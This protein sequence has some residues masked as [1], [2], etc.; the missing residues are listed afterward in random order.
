MI[1]FEGTVWRPALHV[2]ACALSKHKVHYLQSDEVLGDSDHTVPL[3]CAGMHQGG[4]FIVDVG[5]VSGWL[6]YV[7]VEQTNYLAHGHPDAQV[8]LFEALLSTLAGVQ[9][10]VVCFYVCVGVDVCSSVSSLSLSCVACFFCVCVCRGSFE[11]LR[12]FF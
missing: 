10:S 3:T 6:E 11:S 7:A 9:R 5:P 8:F 4:S 2:V 1:L 12:G